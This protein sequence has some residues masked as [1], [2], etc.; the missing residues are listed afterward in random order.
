MHPSIQPCQLMCTCDALSWVHL[1]MSFTQASFVFFLH[2]FQQQNSWCV[3]Q[4]ENQSNQRTEGPY[5][6]WWTISNHYFPLQ[7]LPQGQVL[8]PHNKIQQRETAIIRTGKQLSFQ[9]PFHLRLCTR[10]QHYHPSFKTDTKSIFNATVQNFT[11]STLIA[12]SL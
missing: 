10:M 7:P 2:Q 4:S 11:H 6:A 8:N 12:T 9:A 3:W 5:L 1:T